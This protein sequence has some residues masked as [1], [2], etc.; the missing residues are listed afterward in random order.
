MNKRNALQFIPL[1]QALADGKEIQYNN[2]GEWKD[3]SD[4]TSVAFGNEI[5]HYRI[6]PR[7]WEC[8]ISQCGYL[9]DAAGTI[10]G[11]RPTIRVRE[12]L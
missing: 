3:F 4:P 11:P 2:N 1:I 12:I 5:E 10:V 6:K 7:E 9:I 8:I